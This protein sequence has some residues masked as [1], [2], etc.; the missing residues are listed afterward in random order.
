L[1]AARGVFMT[2]QG[3]EDMLRKFLSFDEMV[4]PAVIQ[5]LYW[6]VIA[7]IVIGLITSL[8][9]GFWGFIGGIVVAVVGFIFWRVY[10]ELIL[11]IFRI[12]AQLGDIARNTAP[13]STP[14]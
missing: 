3:E 12:H 10:C 13:R 7:L 6:I 1:A 14:S 9:H 5:V 2:I 8:F 4:T 11:V